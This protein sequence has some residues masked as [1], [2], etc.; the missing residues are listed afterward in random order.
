MLTHHA[1]QM[2]LHFALKIAETMMF[3]RKGHESWG[4]LLCHGLPPEVWTNWRIKLSRTHTHN[5]MHR[6]S[7]TV[8]TYL[9]ESSSLLPFLFLC[10]SALPTARINKTS[11]CNFA[12]LNCCAS[13]DD[14]SWCR[15]GSLYAKLLRKLKQQSRWKRWPRHSSSC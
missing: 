3:H 15:A 8:Q 4:C 9:T 12:R 11:K 6:H 5:A 13:P 7:H 14:S 10:S 1:K 2:V